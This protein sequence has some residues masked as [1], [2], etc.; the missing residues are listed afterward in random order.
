MAVVSGVHAL[1]RG[2]R[3]SADGKYER[4]ESLVHMQIIGLH[5]AIFEWFLCSFRPPSLALATY[6][7]ER[8]G[9]LSQ[10]AFEAN[11][12]RRC[13]LDNCACVI[14]LDMTIPLL[15]GEGRAW[16]FIMKFASLFDSIKIL[17]E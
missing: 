13:M 16:H 2:R 9:M 17:I 3:W 11:C 10:D 7:L 12:T 4:V 8:G 5:T 14:Y 6:P 15:D 1:V